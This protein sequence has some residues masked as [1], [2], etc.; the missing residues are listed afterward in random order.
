MAAI[1]SVGASTVSA[2]ASVVSGLGASLGL[3]GAGKTATT[4]TTEKKTTRK[5][6]NEALRGRQEANEA[7]RYRGM[8]L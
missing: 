3:S 8:V 1:V 5:E 7:G 4:G 2:G 6:P